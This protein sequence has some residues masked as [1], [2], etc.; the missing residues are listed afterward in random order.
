L[1]PTGASP[2]DTE[3]HTTGGEIQQGNRGDATKATGEST[4]TGGEIQQGNRG[5]ATTAIAESTTTG[6]EIHGGYALKAI[7]D[8]TTTGGEIH[9]GDATKAI[10]ESTTTGGERQRGDATGTTGGEASGEIPF[11]SGKISVFWDFTKID[12]F[13]SKIDELSTKFSELVKLDESCTKFV[14]TTKV[15]EVVAKMGEGC[16]KF[17]EWSTKLVSLEDF[18]GFGL[19]IFWEFATATEFTYVIEFLADIFWPCGP[20]ELI[21]GAVESPWSSAGASCFGFSVGFFCAKQSAIKKGLFLANVGLAHL[22]PWE[23]FF[24]WFAKAEPLENVL[25]Q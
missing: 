22:D 24:W 2:V 21:V 12:E 3:T 19:L 4:T 8:S 14:E 25:V 1:S 15:D 6:G 23:H 20:F 18:P 13:F 7:G 10:G 16:T 9:G 11:I 5:D 17:G